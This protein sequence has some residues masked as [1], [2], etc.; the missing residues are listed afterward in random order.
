[1][2][3]TITEAERQDLGVSQL[4]DVPQVT[5]TELK[6]LFD[7]LG[8]LAIDKFINHITEITDNTASAN[9][10]VV[11]PDD[12]HASE[13]LQSL[14]DEMIIILNNVDGLKHSHGNKETLD[15]ISAEQKAA[16]DSLITL[17]G[18]ITVIQNTLT[19]STTSIP[20]SHAVYAYV[21]SAIGSANF[22][23]P[24]QLLDATYPLGTVYTTTNANFDPASYFGGSWETREMGD[25]LYHF[26][27]KA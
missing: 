17:L 2:F 8:N 5:S 1:M 22:V 27:R 14:I 16:Y 11:V 13:N 6:T 19:D 23:K 25:G 26:V 20:N 10:G 15:S 24:N 4:P 12:Y 21:A 18:A 7:S 9:I 3:T